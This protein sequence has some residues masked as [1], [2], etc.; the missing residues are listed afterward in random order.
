MSLVE[1]L[2]AVLLGSTAITGALSAYATGRASYR[3]SEAI[4]QLNERAQYLLTSLIADIQLAGYYGLNDAASLDAPGAAPASAQLCGEGGVSRLAVPLE[5]H[6]NGYDLSCPA[7][8]AGAMPGSDVLI[9]RRA[10]AQL[11]SAQPGRLQLLTSTVDSRAHRL[12]STG[13]LPAGV[14]LAPGRTELR[15]LLTHFYYVAR[16]A[17][18]PDA[19]QP[20]LRVKNLTAI[21]GRP[22]LIDTEV[23]PGVEDLQVETGYRERASGALRFVAPGSLPAGARIVAV[24]LMLLLRSATTDRRHTDRRSYRYAGRD[25]TP[26]DHFHRLLID[27]TIALR[28]APREGG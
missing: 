12:Q 23:M 27:Q 24:R 8:A 17:D 16:R 20:A 26:G 11:A 3:S 10:S 19:S 7:Q 15:D 1:L 9:L 6:D 21:A 18:G 28:N 2:F 4:S 22:A 25:F 5:V 13:Q 14:S